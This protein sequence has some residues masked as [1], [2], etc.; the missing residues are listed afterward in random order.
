[1]RRWAG[2]RSGSSGHGATE[3]RTVRPRFTRERADLAARF[4]TG[5]CIVLARSDRI[6]QA[7][8]HHVL[9]ECGGR[10]KEAAAPSGARELVW[11]HGQRQC[12]EIESTVPTDV[13]SL[14]PTGV[15]GSGRTAT[16]A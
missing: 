11:K 6:S 4:H 15:E 16:G 8:L 2:G 3:S 14:A 10:V 12:P 7:L 1:M 13:E 5:A 9:K